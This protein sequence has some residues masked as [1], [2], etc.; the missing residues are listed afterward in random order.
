[1]NL[2]GVRPTT[3]A[4]GHKVIAVSD[5]AVNYNLGLLLWIQVVVQDAQEFLVGLDDL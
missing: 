1:M 3:I 2:S 4:L 5:T